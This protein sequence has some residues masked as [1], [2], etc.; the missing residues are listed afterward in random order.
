MSHFSPISINDLTEHEAALI[1]KVAQVSYY[2]ET[3]REVLV[4]LAHGEATLW[5]LPGGLIAT[6]VIPHAGGNELWI[7]FL[8]GRGFLAQAELIREELLL[9]ARKFG[10]VRLSGYTSRPGLARLYEKILGVSPTAILFS[11]KVK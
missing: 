9:A 5:R 1:D 11:Q 6:Q 7:R 4:S 2:G 10:C 8:V 3:T